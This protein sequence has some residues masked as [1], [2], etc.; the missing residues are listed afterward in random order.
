MQEPIQ[1]EM[2]SSAERLQS[3]M[4][5]SADEIISRL[6]E[7]ID[8]L[9]KLVEEADQRSAQLEWQLARMKENE[10]EYIES[11]QEPVYSTPADSSISVENTDYG[12]FD[13]SDA[14][15]NS[16]DDFSQILQDSLDE[17]DYTME[18]EPIRT[19]RAMNAYGANTIKQQPATR[20]LMTVLADPVSAANAKETTD[21]I[22]ET[23]S[24]SIVEEGLDDSINAGPRTAM[25][26]TAVKVRELVREGYSAEDISR[27]MHLGRGAIELI[28]QMDFAMRAEQG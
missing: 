15:T 4:Q 3:E 26:A 20:E 24:V 7:R 23:K 12:M 19:V 5:R 10:N 6:S 17:T 27:R 13:Q 2:E 22:F 9:E 14:A 8:Q 16:E 11:E 1:A 21:D 28:R 25:G 18:N